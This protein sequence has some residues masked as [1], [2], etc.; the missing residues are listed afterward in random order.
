MGR[1]ALGFLLCA[2][3]ARGQEEEYGWLLT[4]Q[5]GDSL[6]CRLDK[7]EGRRLTVLWA[8]APAEPVSFDLDAVS[9]IR[10]AYPSEELPEEGRERLRLKDGSV[11]FGRV[12][13]F[14]PEAVEFETERLGRFV[15]ATSEVQEFVRG[16]IE[17]QLPEQRD[18][19]YVVVTKDGNVLTGRLTQGEG[20]RLVLK[21]DTVTASVDH[22]SAAVVLFP[23]VDGQAAP[24]AD[25]PVP[26]VQVRLKD[27]S[28]LGG[29]DPA[30]QGGVLSFRLGS[31][32]DVKV[33]G[34]ELEQ[35][36]FLDYGAMVGRVGLRTILVWTHY[37]DKEDE[38]KKT[39]DIVAEQLKGW[40]VVEDDSETFDT[41]FRLALAR[42]RTLLIPEMEKWNAVDVATLGREFAAVVTPFLR[43]G[44]NVVICGAQNNH[45]QWLKEANLLDLQVGS[46]VDNQ[47]VLFTADGAALGKGLPASWR[48]LNAT[49]G[50]VIKPGFQAL[51]LAS[52]GPRSVVV[53]RRMGRGW[54]LVLGMDFYLTDATASQVLRAAIQLR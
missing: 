54:L 31:G 23:R 18:E 47:A 30:L 27:G 12:A 34:D 9:D 50:Y 35:L 48:A 17:R 33:S 15:V 29:R 46:T 5:N 21:S 28:V 16:K 22:A 25:Q 49:W 24:A 1:L 32:Q 40:R 42:S 39:L 53:G 37:A 7:L 3:L 14:A 4:F 19:E 8:I 6:H 43:S 10:R 20:G 36:S 45:L 41:D 51:D 2:A 44:G 13:R 38:L 26:G 11:L 52:A